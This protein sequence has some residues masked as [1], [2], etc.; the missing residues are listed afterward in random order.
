MR[1]TLDMQVTLDMAVALHNLLQVS[2]S[3]LLL[4][5]LLQQLQERA[6][7]QLEMMDYC[8]NLLHM[9]LEGTARRFHGKEHHGSLDAWVELV[10]NFLEL[11]TDDH[12]NEVGNWD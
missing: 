11:H 3:H 12:G 6:C 2:C 1:A 5:R 9:L 4:N 10:D 7:L 8:L